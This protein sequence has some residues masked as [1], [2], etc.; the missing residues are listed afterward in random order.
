M[1][2]LL[3]LILTVQLLLLTNDASVMWNTMLYP[4]GCLPVWDVGDE[5][6]LESRVETAFCPLSGGA[7]A[8]G[9]L[10]SHRCSKRAALWF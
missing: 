5:S 7:R 3:A 8:V 4:W 10:P 6:M 9:M 1:L 2:C